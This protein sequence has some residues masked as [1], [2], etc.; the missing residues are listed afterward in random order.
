MD[1]INTENKSIKDGHQDHSKVPRGY[2]MKKLSYSSLVGI[3]LEGNDDDGEIEKMKHALSFQRMHRI[4][5]ICQKRIIRGDHAG[6][7]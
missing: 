2:F 7:N 3:A 4:D 6:T 1:K 5:A